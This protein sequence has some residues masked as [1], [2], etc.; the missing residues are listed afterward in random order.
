MGKQ[1]A[2][3]AKALYAAVVAGLGSLLA[4]VTGHTSLSQVT[5]SQWIVVALAA[6]V[7]GGGVYGIPNGK[8][9]SPAPPPPA[10]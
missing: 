1:L 10:A 9:S 2:V 7:A 6:I 8:G 5:A 3:A 4:V